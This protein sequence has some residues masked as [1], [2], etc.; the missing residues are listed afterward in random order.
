MAPE[1]EK[2][3]EAFGDRCRFLKVDSDEEPEVASILKINGL[4]TILF[5]NDMSVV[6]R[7]EGALM[8]DELRKLIDYHFFYGPKPDID[9]FQQQS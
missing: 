3:A 4:P 9:G 2:A 1:L 7:A 6:M 5:I 8:A